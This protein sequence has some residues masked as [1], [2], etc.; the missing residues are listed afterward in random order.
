[1]IVVVSILAVV[2]A[3]PDLTIRDIQTGRA[4]YSGSVLGYGSADLDGVYRFDGRD[5]FS[6]HAWYADNSLYAT[7][8]GCTDSEAWATWGPLVRGETVE[9]IWHEG[10]ILPIM[11]FVGTLVIVLVVA[12]RRKSAREPSGPEGPA[13]PRPRA[14]R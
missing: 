4:V 2:T 10:P 7:R 6:Y 1:M 9:C 13:R 8:F 14:G 5:G 11:L 12:R 3:V